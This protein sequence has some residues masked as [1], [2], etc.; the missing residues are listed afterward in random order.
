MNIEETISNL[1][2]NKDEIFNN[3]KNIKEPTLIIGS[4]G[5]RV[6]AEFASRVLSKKNKILTRVLD[7]RDLHYEDLELYDNIFIISYSG[8]N[9]G[10]KA[11]FIDNKNIYLLSKRK[12]KI[13]DETLLH[14]EME[15]HDSFISLESTIIPMTILLE[16][17]LEDNYSDYITKILEELDEDL[18]FDFSGDYINI[19]SGIDSSVTETFLES[20]CVES[21][22]IIP[23]IHRKYDYC[24]GRSTINK[25]HSSVSIYLSDNGSDLDNTLKDVLNDTMSR[26]LILKQVF[27][28]SVV[29]DYYLCLQCMYLLLNIAKSKNID[30]RKIKYDRDAV[31][32]LYYFKGSM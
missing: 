32:K 2:F 25:N 18:S 19:F 10:V 8:S 13:K 29:N 31:K 23:L 20:T 1:R 16:Y 24:H 30:L 17:Y 9:Y 26:N 7:A 15:E 12:T 5:S 3:L 11:S 22:L 4:G 14:Y 27:E 6:V 28:D 21:G